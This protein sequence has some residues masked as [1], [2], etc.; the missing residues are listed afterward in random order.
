MVDNPRTYEAR[1][2]IFVIKIWLEDTADDLNLP[3]WRGHITHIPSDKR[4]PL[5]GM[6]DLIPLIIPFLDE[7]GIDPSSLQP[8][9]TE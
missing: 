6:G 9:A 5:K 1:T 3:I 7:I 8:N 2:H 4:Y